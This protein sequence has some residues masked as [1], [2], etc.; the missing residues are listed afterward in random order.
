MLLGEKYF[1]LNINIEGK[2]KIGEQLDADKWLDTES[3]KGIATIFYTEHSLA[4]I[5]NNKD[6]KF[7]TDYD[8]GLFVKEFDG[9][10]NN[11]ARIVS[12]GKKHLYIYKQLGE[13]GDLK[14]DE[15]ELEKRERKTQI[16]PPKGFKIKMIAKESLKHCPLVLVT[17]K[18]NQ[19]MARGTFKEIKDDNPLLFGSYLAMNYLIGGSK[20]QQEVADFREYLQCLSSI[21]F[22][23]LIAKIYE[24]KGYHV[25]AYKGGFMKNFD[26]FCTKDGE[27]TVSLQIKLY[28]KSKH[29]K[30]IKEFNDTLFY[31]VNSEIKNKSITNIRNHSDILDDLN[32]LKEKEREKVKRWLEKTLDWVKPNYDKARN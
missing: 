23:T 2:N 27:G 14:G 32:N 8:G 12:I 15:F 7:S 9:R 31:C 19:W 13:L 30:I 5:R 10:I 16:H 22:E 21:E 4:D 26:L 25:P 11:N 20:K 3:G 24:S 1:L 17:I 6:D 18:S 28:L 29:A